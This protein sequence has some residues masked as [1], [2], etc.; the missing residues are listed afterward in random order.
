MPLILSVDLTEIALFRNSDETSGHR[1]LIIGSQIGPGTSRQLPF[2]NRIMEGLSANKK[3]RTDNFRLARGPGARL[4]RPPSGQEVTP[5][6]I[7]RLGRILPAER[8]VIANR[9][10]N[11]S[12]GERYEH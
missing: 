7:F 10:D 8:C 1:D 11:D 5:P 4:S 12:E 2:H 6:K 3:L 9:K